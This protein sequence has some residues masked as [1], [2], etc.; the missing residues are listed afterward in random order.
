VQWQAQECRRHPVGD[1]QLR[2]DAEAP[3]V[4]RR[5]QGDV[6]EGRLDAPRA[7]RPQRGVALAGLFDP[8]APAFQG[9]QLLLGFA[10]NAAIV[11]R[12]LAQALGRALVVTLLALVVVT[13][14]GVA[15]GIAVAVG[16][17]GLALSAG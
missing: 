6:V 1:G 8:T 4:R 17:A 5:V 15:I 9:V 7:E 13:A 11:S 10:L 14:V 2:V 16:I 3:R 12:M